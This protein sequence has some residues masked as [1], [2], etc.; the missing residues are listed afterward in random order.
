MP[1]LPSFLSFPSYSWNMS[2]SFMTQWA[3]ML[4]TSEASPCSCLLRYHWLLA[5]IFFRQPLLVCFSKVCSSLLWDVAVPCVT[6]FRP[7]LIYALISKQF[8]PFHWR[9]LPLTKPVSVQTLLQSS[10]SIFF[11]CRMA[12][13]HGLLAFS[14][15]WEKILSFFPKY[16]PLWLICLCNKHSYRT[17]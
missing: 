8:Y 15:C 7:L 2:F 3:V 4:L 13:S 16:V 14:M 1:T 5:L 6:F 17:R 11:N 10:K 9:Q 12:M